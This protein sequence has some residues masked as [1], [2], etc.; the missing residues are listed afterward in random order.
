MLAAAVVIGLAGWIIIGICIVIIVV[1]LIYI[2]I[3]LLASTQT[4]DWADP[5]V[6]LGKKLKKIQETGKMEDE[7]CELLRQLLDDAKKAG[8]PESV[9]NKLTEL[10]DE[11]CN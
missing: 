3:K 1:C 8:L 5:L 7:D 6:K 2:G 9:G 11:L 4:P 10:L